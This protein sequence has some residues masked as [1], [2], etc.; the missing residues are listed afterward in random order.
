ML[1]P[2]NKVILYHVTRHWVC[3]WSR[4]EKFFF[5]PWAPGFVLQP[6]FSN[7]YYTVS[8]NIKCISL[9]ISE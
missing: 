9:Y 2:E 8:A 3:A 7:I 4:F 6:S 5:R 1:A